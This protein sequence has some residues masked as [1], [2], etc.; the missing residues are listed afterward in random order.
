[1]I[2]GYIMLIFLQ[3][4]SNNSIFSLFSVSAQ[5]LGN[6]EMLYDGSCK[7]REDYS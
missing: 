4:L 1:M 5:L 6:P 3:E 7:A 2:A